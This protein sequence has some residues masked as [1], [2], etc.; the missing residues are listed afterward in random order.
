MS[1]KS[2]PREPKE[3]AP[4]QPAPVATKDEIPSKEEAYTFR[5]WASI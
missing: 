5:D 1:E 4:Q 3:T 2:A